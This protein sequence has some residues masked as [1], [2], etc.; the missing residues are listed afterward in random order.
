MFGMKCSNIE[1]VIYEMARDQM[2]DAA[3]AEKSLAHIN[4]CAECAA[5]LD[6]QRSIS[7]GLQALAASY[8]EVEAPASVEAAL[9]ESFRRLNQSVENRP[10]KAT[11]SFKKSSRTYIFK[12]AAAAAILLTL[13]IAVWQLERAFSKES[14][15]QAVNPPQ[16]EQPAPQQ[17]RKEEP[18]AVKKEIQPRLAD[19]KTTPLKKRTQRASTVAT[20]HRNQSST[21]Q[22]VATTAET[23]T[24]FIPLVDL[25]NIR[26]MDRGRVLRVQ[27]PRSTMRSFGLPVNAARYNEPVTADVLVG[28]DGFA[29][30]IRFVR[31]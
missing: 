8:K 21:V 27:M 9:L 2:V 13:G 7:N 1:S 19:N 15:Q 24:E 14:R 3:L 16:V 31:Q 25:E 30:A 10:A 12:Y 4:N 17:E 28:D 23:V 29:R 5:K 18:K 11:G 26:G 6:Q 20:A 22:N